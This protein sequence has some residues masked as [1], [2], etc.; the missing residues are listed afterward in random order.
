[1]RTNVLGTIVL[2]CMLAVFTSCGSKTTGNTNVKEST[3]EQFEPDIRFA[4]IDTLVYVLTEALS[5]SS[6][7][8]LEQHYEERS[9][10]M[11]SYWYL[12]H[13]GGDA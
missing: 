2:L 8:E 5:D 4:T 13:K 1:M 9:L 6:L 3:V 11:K 7:N 10:A 12:N